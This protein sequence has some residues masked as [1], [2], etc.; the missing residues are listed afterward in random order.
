MDKT[1]KT[2]TTVTKV[3]VTRREHTEPVGSDATQEASE[4]TVLHT[5]QTLREDIDRAFERVFH[6]WPTPT[7]WTK[8]WRDFEPL[9]AFRPPF[10]F[11]RG[12]LSPRA[13]VSETPE[14]YEIA[15]E[16]PGVEP[17]DINVVLAGNRLTV[18]GQKHAAREK[19]ERDY[20]VAERSYGAF[21]RSFTLP[22]DFDP[23]R[24]EASYKA[25]V[26]TVRLPRSEAKDKPREIPVK[27]A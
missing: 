9:K 22:D 26:L 23:D 7:A 18:K 8:S 19:S 13:E 15:V 16:I 21:A 12:G 25:G 20:Y 1:A 4:S 17:S 2:D 27:A 14:A 5:L 3:D 11:G 24:I 6:S 10:G